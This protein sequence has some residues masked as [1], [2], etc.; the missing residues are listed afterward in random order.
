MGQ[1]IDHVQTGHV[2]LVEVID[3]VRLLLAEDRHQ[4]VG[5]GDLLLAGGLHVVDGALQHPLEAQRGLGV[6]AIVFGQDRHRGVDRLLQLGAQALEVGARSLQHG[7]G[8]CVFKQGQQQMFN[9]HVFVTGFPGAL[10]ALTNG[11]L[12]VFTEHKALRLRLKTICGL[13][14]GFPAP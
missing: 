5:A 4:H 9:R 3:R 12:E 14:S 8:G 1:I 7:L 2:L 13:A 11:L 10:V 6:A